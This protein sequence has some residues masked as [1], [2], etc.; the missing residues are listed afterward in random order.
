[1]LYALD[2][3]VRQA[4]R[5]TAGSR[6]SYQY[7]RILFK[8]NS[9]NS[10]NTLRDVSFNI[11]LDI[12]LQRLFRHNCWPYSLHGLIKVS[13]LGSHSISKRLVDPS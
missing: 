2:S 4:F 10:I 3:A 11:S 1:M 5:L 9:P 6:L 8:S 13:L 12:T 7:Y